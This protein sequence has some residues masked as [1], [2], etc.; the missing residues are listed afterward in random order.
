MASIEKLVFLIVALTVTC[1]V[2]AKFQSTLVV[3]A[4]EDESHSSYEEESYNPYKEKCDV[5][6]SF[7]NVEESLR[8]FIFL[9]DVEKAAKILKSNRT[10]SLAAGFTYGPE[11]QCAVVVSE[12]RENDP[13]VVAFRV[14]PLFSALKAKPLQA[15]ALHVYKYGNPARVAKIMAESFVSDCQTCSG[16][17][18]LP[19][20]RRYIFFCSF[21][22]CG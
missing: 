16:A 22:G 8:S 21:Y 12:D 20:L 7:E 19:F 10:F 5:K 18:S 2:K 11:E 14:N 13:D 15:A 3:T 9:A 17:L 1:F 6:T 4:N